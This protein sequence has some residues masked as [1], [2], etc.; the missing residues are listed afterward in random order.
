MNRIKVSEERNGRSVRR[1]EEDP[2]MIWASS[3]NIKVSHAEKAEDQGQNIMLFM[4]L[5]FTVSFSVSLSLSSHSLFSL[6]SP[7]IV[8]HKKKVKLYSVFS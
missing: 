8:S 7:L 1:R 4:L 6:S 2:S 3:V 5:I